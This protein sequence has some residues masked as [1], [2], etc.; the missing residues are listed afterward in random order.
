[1][2]DDRRPDPTAGRRL[3]RAQVADLASGV[4]LAI[5]SARRLNLPVE[6]GVSEGR[7]ALVRWAVLLGE[8]IP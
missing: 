4:D 5:R 6:P 2:A 7:E 1:M 8:V 3:L